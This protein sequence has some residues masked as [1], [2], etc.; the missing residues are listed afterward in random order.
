MLKGRD[1]NMDRI[2]VKGFKIGEK[3][4]EYKTWDTSTYWLFKGYK[5]IHIFIYKLHIRIGW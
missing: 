4:I 5:S 2:K 3:T 1:K